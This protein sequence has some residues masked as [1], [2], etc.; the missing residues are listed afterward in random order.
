M[1][2]S[3]LHSVRQTKSVALVEFLTRIRTNY[4]AKKRRKN[5]HS[6]ISD[7]RSVAITSVYIICHS[8]LSCFIR[9]IRF[10]QRQLTVNRLLNIN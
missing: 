9:K 3:I 2:A 5:S 6:H 8:T 7:E 4:D 10:H 1:P